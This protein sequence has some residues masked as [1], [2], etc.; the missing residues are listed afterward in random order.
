M[1]QQSFTQVLCN[2][3]SGVGLT[4]KQDWQNDCMTDWWTGQKHQTG[5]HKFFFYKNK[6]TFLCEYI[7]FFTKFLFQAWKIKLV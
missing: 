6:R 4:K 2:G 1:Y 7:L 3:I 5:A